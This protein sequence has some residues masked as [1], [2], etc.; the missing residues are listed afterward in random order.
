M[1]TRSG[2]VV[3]VGITAILL[4]APLGPARGGVQ[5]AQPKNS[6]QIEGVRQGPEPSPSEQRRLDPDA[7]QRVQLHPSARSAESPDP[8]V[9]AP[10]LEILRDALVIARH[11][12]GGSAVGIAAAGSTCP[13]LALATQAG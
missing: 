10:Q 7:L 2:P 11:P 4:C 9:L 12:T 3:Y 13:I 8:S 6:V 1:A 5:E